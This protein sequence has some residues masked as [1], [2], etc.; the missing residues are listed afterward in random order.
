MVLYVAHFT[1]KFVVYNSKICNKFLNIFFEQFVQI[2]ILHN[3][4][5][6]GE[7]S[8]DLPTFLPLTVKLRGK[9]IKIF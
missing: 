8:Q 9:K 4:C 2:P 1:Q 7:D 3:I 6:P 5:I